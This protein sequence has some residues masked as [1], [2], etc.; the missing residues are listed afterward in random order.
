MIPNMQPVVIIT[1]LFFAITFIQSGYD[2]IMDWKG[3]INWLKSHFANT[4]IKNMVPQSLL[5]I[6]ILEVLSGAFSVIGIVQIVVND[7]L[8][9]A[10]LSGILSCLTLLFLLLGQRLAKD[11]DGARTIVIY[12]IPAILLLSW[13]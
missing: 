13:L 5:L 3:N 8:D 9:F 4:P 7:G 1:L 2:K 10:F 6:L 11:Y 12:F